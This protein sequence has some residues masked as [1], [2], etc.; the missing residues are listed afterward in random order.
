MIAQFTFY[1]PEKINTP[2]PFKVGAGFLALNAF[3]FTDTDEARAK[4]DV[5]LVVIGSVYPTTK[6]VKLTFPLYIGGG[7][8]LKDQKWFFL[9]GPGIR[10]RF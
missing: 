2:R 1:H 5:G 9:V 6:D 3:N 4:R 8:Q 7:Y 10:I